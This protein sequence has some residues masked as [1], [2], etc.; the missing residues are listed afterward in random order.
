MNGCSFQKNIWRKR[1]TETTNSIHKR[2]NKVLYT[3]SLVLLLI[4]A[5]AI[6]LINQGT[7]SAKAQTTTSIPS[8]LLKYEWPS[9][10]ASPSRSFFSDGPG[11]NAPNIAWKATIPG[12][13][14]EAFHYSGAAVVAVGGKVI[15][16]CDSLTTFG[17][18]FKGIT[19]AYD[20]GTGALIWQRE[21]ISSRNIAKITDDYIVVGSRCLSI[22]DGST[23][24]TGPTGFS[25]NAGL[26]NGAGYIPELK[27]FVDSTYGWS[28]PDPSQPPALAW[29]LT[30]TQNIGVGSCVY[31]DGKLF[32][33]TNDYDIKAV[34]A[35]TGTELWRT[36]YTAGVS[37]G[38]SYADGKV[39]HGG[40]DNNMDCWDANT[41]KLLWSYNPHTWYGQWASSSGYAYG[42]IYEHNQDNYIYAINATTGQLVWRQGGPGIWYSN[43]LSIADGK[44]YVQ[45]GEKEYRDFD[46]GEF[47]Y[48]EFDCFDAYTGELVWTLP[49]ENGAPFNFQCN[50]YGNLYVIPT[51]SYNTP[52]V[53]E[54]SEYVG[55]LW[56]ISDN[57]NNG[58]SMFMADAAHSGE[59]AGPTNLKLKWTF[60]AGAQIV[61]PATCVNG[62]TYF[63]ASNNKIYAVDANTGVQKWAFTTGFKMYSAP[64]VVNGK[65]YTGADDGNI[66]CIDANTGSQ[67]WKTFAGGVTNNIL[68]IGQSQTRASPMVF[69]GKV[70]VGSLDGNL[71]CLDANTG[72]VIWK[73]MG[74]SPCVILATPAISDNAIYLASTRGGYKVGSGSAV[75][76]GD[77]YKLNLEGNV[78][79]HKEIP[80]VL[81]ATP[82]NG[83]W[84]FA[85]PTVA[86]D[87]GLVFLRNGYR[88]NY[89]FNT[90]TGDVVW[91]YDGRYNPGTPNQAGGAPQI[92]AMLYRYGKVYF[93][94]FYGVV[95]LNALNGSE[96]WYTYLSREIN[97][98]GITY[99]YGRV[100]ASTEA[101][102]LYVLDSQSGEKL[103]YN[104]F[105]T[106]ALHASATPYNGNIYI[107]S[108]DWNMYCFG[109]AKLMSDQTTKSIEPEPS[110]QSAAPVVPT[111]PVQTL[112]PSV[113]ST[114]S[115]VTQ[116]ETS[117]VTYAV[118][119]TVV[120]IVLIA[121][122]GLFRKRKS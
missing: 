86:P 80:Y 21:G 17:S 97:N 35:K 62:V 52:G 56:C 38:M 69:N 37:Y 114:P 110:S 51:I 79:W 32:I 115:V 29:N 66:Y 85:A 65:V 53:F 68:A 99:A 50:A 91:T 78:I 103:S 106:V 76:N 22:V 6:P 72:S 120:I 47:A 102:V 8:N 54:G 108:S 109:D 101:G 30:S 31:G 13:A 89:A 44:V 96:V 36:P 116:G 77:F 67:I 74:V 25:I 92:D 2:K 118:I 11:P 63:G 16:T 119:A 33:L 64:A 23:V 45:M 107:G 98:Q 90:T 95:C 75:S 84:L 48:S 93:G 19:C 59:G 100:Y 43:T 3:F 122:V 82:N 87:I 42:M 9:V 55:E 5:M 24:W 41:G 105:G 27:M 10:P 49:M 46:S 58:W 112:A 88:L 81:N 12:I 117:L 111:A 4:I 15:I 71:Y 39:F 57:V 60:N 40:L 18:P 20:A 1:L 28:L 94:D 70:Y 14:G 83:N 73:F 61:S 113:T 34:D 26:T 7:L 121:V 104:D